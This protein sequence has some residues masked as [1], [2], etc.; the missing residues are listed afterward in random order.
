MF[1]HIQLQK[2]YEMKSKS[3]M[4]KFEFWILRW[5]SVPRPAS[6]PDSQSH[7]HSYSHTNECQ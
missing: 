7:R 2:I 3:V 5:L 4:E 6:Q 1:F